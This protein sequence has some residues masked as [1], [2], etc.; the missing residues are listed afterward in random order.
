MFLTDRFTDVRHRQHREDE[1]LDRTDE[2]A[3]REPY[4]IR[5]GEPHRDQEAQDDDKYFPCQ[6]IAEQTERKRDRLGDLFDNL[7]NDKRSERL[8]EAL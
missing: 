8:E 4:D 1:C 2:Y 7:D 3:E 5:N 6:D